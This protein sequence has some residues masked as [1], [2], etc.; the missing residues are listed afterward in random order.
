MLPVVLVDSVAVVPPPDELDELEVAPPVETLL[1][2]PLSVD[3]VVFVCASA[4][5]DPEVLVV[6][7]LVVAVMV[8]PVL[9]V[10]AS[11]SPPA[12]VLCP[13]PPLVGPAVALAVSV[14]LPVDGVSEEHAITK[15]V[16]PTGSQIETRVRMLG[17]PSAQ[18][19]R[20]EGNLGEKLRSS[21]VVL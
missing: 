18:S 14:P 3:D 21:A 11:P 8:V 16:I 4:P 17:L 5:P 9:L 19:W 15:A 7:G 13:V 20:R 2:E 12:T 10:D 6:A 1:G